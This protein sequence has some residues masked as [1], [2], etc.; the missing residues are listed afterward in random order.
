MG[1]KENLQRGAAMMGHQQGKL[2][3]L[4]YRKKHRNRVANISNNIIANQ[5]QSVQHKALITNIQIKL[6]RKNKK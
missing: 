5:R 2:T 4:R 3:I 1:R 6:K